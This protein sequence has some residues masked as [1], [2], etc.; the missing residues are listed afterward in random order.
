MGISNIICDERWKP[1]LISDF[2]VLMQYIRRDLYLFH[3]ITFFVTLYLTEDYFLSFT[4]IYVDNHLKANMRIMKIY[5]FANGGECLI[6]PFSQS[7]IVSS[8]RFFKNYSLRWHFEG[9]RNC[10]VI[11]KNH[12]MIILTIL[13][14]NCV[15]AKWSKFNS[16][17]KVD[18]T[19]L[20]L[21]ETGYLHGK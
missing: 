10:W 13:R 14:N 20:A 4:W 18:Y 12:Q 9:N 19:Q 16:G 8:L 5:V 17:S 15:K 6:W 3:W 1:R 2:L 21:S 7:Q 11:S